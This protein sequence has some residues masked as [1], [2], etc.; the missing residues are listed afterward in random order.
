MKN[1]SGILTKKTANEKVINWKK[2]QKNAEKSIKWA[3]Y[4]EKKWDDKDDGWK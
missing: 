1:N 4:E 3:D 2:W